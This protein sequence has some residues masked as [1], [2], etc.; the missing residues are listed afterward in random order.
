MSPGHGNDASR[1]A[2]GYESQAYG[3]DA[4][5]NVWGTGPMHGNDAS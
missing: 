3:N 5:L 2:R 4:S 1:L